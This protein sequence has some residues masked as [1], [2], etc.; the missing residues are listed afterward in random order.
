M[1]FCFVFLVNKKIVKSIWK[2]LLSLRGWMSEKQNYISVD[3]VTSRTSVYEVINKLFAKPVTQMSSSRKLNS[4]CEKITENGWRWWRDK[5]KTIFKKEKNP[6]RLTS[7]VVCANPTPTGWH[8]WWLCVF[9]FFF[10]VNSRQSAV[11]PWIFLKTSCKKLPVAR[12]GRIQCGRMIMHSFINHHF[13][14]VF[15]FL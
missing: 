9:F 14:F 3:E 8:H 6:K 11:L 7:F 10:K 13:C 15:F 4:A 1:I 2:S 5:Q 12:N